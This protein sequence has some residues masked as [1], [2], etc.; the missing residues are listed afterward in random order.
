VNEHLYRSV[1]VSYSDTFAAVF[2]SGLYDAWAEEG[3]VIPVEVLPGRTEE[4][5][6]ILKP[7]IVPFISYP[8]EWSFSSYK[9][10]ALLTLSLAKKSLASGLIL[11]DASAYNTQFRGTTPI[12]IDSLSFDVYQEGEP[13]IA[14]GQ[15]CR[16]FLGPLFLMSK[17]DVRLQALMKHY[18][19][20][21]PIGLTAELLRDRVRWNL[22]F[23]LHIKMHA[24]AIE[25]QQDQTTR[26]KKVLSRQ[27][28]HVLLS[29][30]EDLVKSL[31]LPMMN[32]EWANYYQ[33]TNYN[34]EAFSH[35]KRIVAEWLGQ[36][37]CS[38][39]TCWDLGANEGV[40]SKIAAEAG[41][42]TVAWDIDPMAIE[43]LAVSEGT[44]LPLLLDLTNPSPGIGWQNRERDSFSSRGP[45]DV[46]LALALIHH[47]RI[48]NNT[49]FGKIAELFAETSQYLI[50]EFVAK[51]DSM[52]QKLLQSRED[53]FHDYSVEEFLRSFKPYFDV[54]AQG[55]IECSKR[56]LF[57]MER[58]KQ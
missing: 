12:L 8:Y 24:K 42:A 25:G 44:V 51:D 54:L 58:R 4:E 41:F 16:H 7:E 30:L 14:Y 39:R 2:E 49:P 43:K 6:A 55:D 21:I 34:E 17:C 31:S 10:A 13:W 45:V 33:E 26:K 18:L 20:G 29:S 48:G 19:D 32:T 11:K 23:N 15:F 46:V 36:L 1:F 38:R 53:V 50:I 52:V 22:G 35:K 40:F 27:S 28:L 9:K 37:D 5:L 56:S 47:L 57:L 3:L